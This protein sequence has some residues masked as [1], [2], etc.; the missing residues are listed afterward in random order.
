MKKILIALAVLVVVALGVVI[1][2]PFFIDVN[3]YKPTIEAKAKE[4]LGRELKL[5]GPIKLSLWPNIG[6]EASDVHLANVAGGQAKDVASLKSLVVSVK[7]MPLLSRTVEVDSFVLN[8]PVI[9]LE[10]DK[11]G[12]PNWQF[13]DQKAPAPK[14]GA[15]GGAP[16]GALKLGDVR[17]V[18]GRLGYAN[19]QTGD[20]Q[21]L[22]QINAKALLPDM[23]SPFKLE[24]SAVWN[25]E[26]VDLNLGTGPLS[27]LQAGQSTPV[28]AKLASK[29]L[30]LE[31]DGNA[32]VKDTATAASGAV[33]LETPSI[34]D[35][36]AWAGK[37]L[38]NAQPNTMGRLSIKGK[39]AL[40][41]K[42]LDFTDAKIAVDA[43]NAQGA[44]SVDA[45]GAK[46]FVKGNLDVDK[47]DANPYLGPEQ[48]AKP[49]P[50]GQAGGGEWSDEPIDVS[51]LKTFDADLAAS[52]GQVIFRKMKTGKATVKLAVKDGR[53]ALDLGVP[54]PGLYQGEGTVNVV[55]NAGPTPAS[56]EVKAKLAGLQAQPFLVD[57]ND[58]DRLSG[59][60]AAD[61]DLNARGMT[62]RQ[63]MSAL[64]G[65]GGVKFTD[66]AIKSIDLGGIARQIE[67]MASATGELD[68]KK[69]GGSFGAMFGGGTTE[70]SDFSELG[71]TF[72]ADK[73]VFTNKDLALKSPFLRIAGAGTLTAPS[74][75]WDYG[76]K[77]EPV[78]TRQGQGGAAGSGG[79]LT[80]QCKGP[81]LEFS[82]C[83]PDFMGLAQGLMKSMG[84][85]FKG[86]IPGLGGAG[87]AGA[88]G[89]GGALPKALPGAGGL[90]GL[91][92]SS[93]TAPAA[94]TP[95]PAAP[96]PA[97]GGTRLPG[98]LPG[99]GFKLPGQ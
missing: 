17:L 11:A 47:L 75:T 81:W 8:E 87:A 97:T 12:K 49:A 80:V 18:N 78:A 51:G 60:L 91:G 92:G 20:R 1:A 65:K 58:T 9:N 40:A 48:P 79:G 32:T 55:V 44:L 4:A 41:G 72:T 82:G 39:L 93:T 73:G 52:A 74:R 88:G 37:P 6:V 54:K 85:A 63:I 77:L 53:M 2:L 71:G 45:G 24:G 19:L 89:L 28:K 96:A 35:L 10:V 16:A 84:G 59:Q 90:P 83:A 3:A 14:P 34:K 70:K 15:A 57:A 36:A 42:K 22:E 94:T 95:A 31:F 13:G 43:I 86:I 27:K 5:N 76:L 7:L 23:D 64:A 38:Q 26:K 50:A 98:G 25:K 46:P 67:N 66:G 29:N 62:Q 68:L 21:Q 61:V 99:G 30:T 56:Y 69:M 33:S